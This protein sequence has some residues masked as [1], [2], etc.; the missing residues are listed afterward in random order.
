MGTL[1]RVPFCQSPKAPKPVEAAETPTYGDLR[2]GDSGGGGELPTARG[3]GPAPAL[4]PPGIRLPAAAAEGSRVKQTRGRRASLGCSEAA[5]LAPQT[6]ERRR[7]WGRSLR[8]LP[9]GKRP[10]LIPKPGPRPLAGRLSPPQPPAPL[11]KRTQPPPEPPHSFC[12]PYRARRVCQPP[13]TRVLGTRGGR[14][15]GARAKAE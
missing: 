4:A 6:S 3:W 2:P 14:A 12:S 10:L 5:A 8:S 15:R 7:C 1:P 9:Q 11:R 13:H